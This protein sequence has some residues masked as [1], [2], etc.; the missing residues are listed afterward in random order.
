MNAPC[1]T[2]SDLRRFWSKVDKITSSNGCWLWIAFKAPSGHGKFSFGNEQLAHRVS[3]IIA[4]GPPPLDKPC[5]LHNCPGGDNPS[6]VNPAHLWC[7]T[8]NDNNQDAIIKGRVVYVSGDRH[9]SRLHPERRAIGLRNGKH[10][11]PECT[12]RGDKHWVRIHPELIKKGEAVCGSKLTEEKVREIREVYAAGGVSTR[13]LAARF[14]VS[15]S[16]IPKVV[17]RKVWRHVA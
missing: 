1:F 14:D 2:Q 3:W 11:K 10:T 15:Q 16:L 5:V 12:P 13:Q 6:C 17:N 4:F 7:G 9:G 8:I